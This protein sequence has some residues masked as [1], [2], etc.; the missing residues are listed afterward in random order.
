MG[1][2]SFIYRNSYS[3]ASIAVACVCLLALLIRG[4]IFT[5]RVLSN[6]KQGNHW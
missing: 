3:H 5:S 4:S 2:E 6:I 1:A